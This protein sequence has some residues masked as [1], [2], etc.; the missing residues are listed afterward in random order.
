[1][2]T[3]PQLIEDD[4]QAFD[5]A[6]GELV[7]KS[8]AQLALLVAKA[9]NLVHECGQVD[10]CDT[11]N[12]ATLAANSFNATEFMANLLGETDFSSMY[13]QGERVSTL[14]LNIDERALL[15]VIFRAQLSVGVIKYYA[16]QTVHR[17]ADQLQL[18]ETR[19][20]GEVFDP[21][22]LNVTEADQF[23]KKKDP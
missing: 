21:A 10:Q 4:K 11:T 3:F 7:Q 22:L 9:G 5:A 19:A 14:I 2:L 12:V 16:N 1:M 8:E 15:V 13:Q 6:L 17:L 20:P 23:F 18:A